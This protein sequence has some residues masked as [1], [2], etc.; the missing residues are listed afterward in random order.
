MVFL[1]FVFFFYCLFGSFGFAFLC[2]S[3][4]KAIGD[5]CEACCGSKPD[6][7]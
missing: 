6:F 1:V 7:R 3:F 2:F 5:G 4:E